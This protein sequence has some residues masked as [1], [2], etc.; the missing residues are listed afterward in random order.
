MYNSHDQSPLL[1]FLKQATKV[2][3]YALFSITAANP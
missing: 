1:P 2:K 3:I